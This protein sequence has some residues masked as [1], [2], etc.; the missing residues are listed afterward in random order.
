[1]PVLQYKSTADDQR[2]AYFVHFFSTIVLLYP[3]AAFHSAFLV[4]SAN[5]VDRRSPFRLTSF[6]C[7]DDRC[8]QS[9]LPLS[10]VRNT[11]PTLRVRFLTLFHSPPLAVIVVAVL[12]AIIFVALRRMLPGP[13]DLPLQTQGIFGTVIPTQYRRPI[14]STV[15]WLGG[16]GLPLSRYTRAIL[17]GL[18]PRSNS[19]EAEVDLQPSSPT[20]PVVV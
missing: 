13:P 16:Q 15:N 10:L 18:F 3:V 11:P 5:I 19:P 7:C 12:C 2:G 8:N 14:Q 9:S 6:S 1:M 17:D 4:S 20:P